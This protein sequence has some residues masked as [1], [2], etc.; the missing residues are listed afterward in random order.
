MARRP[1]KETFRFKRG[2]VSTKPKLDQDNDLATTG[3]QNILFLGRAR[4]RP[5]KGLTLVGGIGTINPLPTGDGIA[6]L[7]TKS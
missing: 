1:F 4:P 7:G 5:F 6:G 3:S 2:Y